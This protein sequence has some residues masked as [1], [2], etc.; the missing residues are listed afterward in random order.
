MFA[1]LAREI[2][3]ETIPVSNDTFD[4][5]LRQPYGVVGSIFPYNHPVYFAASKI[6]APIQTGNTVVV[7]PPEQDPTG[8]L[9]LGRLLVEH[10]VFPDGVVNIVSGF[11]DEAGSAL[12]SHRK[13]RK[14]GFTGGV[15]TGARIQEQAAGTITDVLFELGGKNP[16]I[17]YPDADLK[18][19][20]DEVVQSMNLTWCGQSCGSISRLF[21]HESEYEEGLGF[22]E[23]SLEPLTPGDS[24]DPST[25]MGCLVS[26]EQLSK[27]MSFIERGKETDMRLIT[28]GGRPDGEAVHEGHYIEPTVFADASPDL[29]I[30]HE[31]SF[32]PLLLVFRWS[33]EDRVIEMANDV[34][35]G[36]TAGILT[37]NLSRAHSVAE[38]LEA[39][40]VWVNQAGTH[41]LGAPFG[42]W[43]Q[44]GIGSEEAIQELHEY[45]Q[46]KNV[47]VQL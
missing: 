1:G 8:V 16:G 47:N 21:L 25:E 18:T 22:L 19:A 4:Y 17:I 37:E 44:S 40:N 15:E 46:L 28:G 34:E 3:G 26:E 11:G 33:D 12:V 38:R 9:E 32:G 41:Y 13:V 5:T 43:K 6:A 42:G 36:L 10:E 39:G 29:D 23:T 14:I 7:K 35:Y 2:K 20:I 31:E 45:T 27:V 30:A 24:L